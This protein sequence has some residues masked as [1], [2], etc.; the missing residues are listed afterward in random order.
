MINYKNNFLTEHKGNSSPK[1]DDL[2]GKKFGKWYIICRAPSIK[3][4][5]VFWCECSCG[6]IKEVYSTHLKRGISKSCL[7]CSAQKL[8]SGKMGLVGDIPKSFW[9]EFVKKSVGEKARASRRNLKF[10]LTIEDAWN[11]YLKQKGKCALSGIPIGFCQS[12][13]TDKYGYKKKWLNT[14]SLDRIDSKKDYILENVQWV[15]KDINIMK[16]VFNQEYFINICRL[17]SNNHKL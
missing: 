16:N 13:T 12:F 11:L 15:H 9:K 8:N 2:T 5:T 1:F 14:A 4:R 10:D 3:K 7:K 6:V 17:I